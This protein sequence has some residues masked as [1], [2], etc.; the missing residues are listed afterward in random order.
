MVC[1]GD[2]RVDERRTEDRRAEDRRDGLERRGE[3]CGLHQTLKQEIDDLKDVI[4]KHIGPLLGFMNR[5]KGIGITLVII[6][7]AF[8]TF[9]L[10][11]AVLLWGAV[12][13]RQSDH[14]VKVDSKM[15]VLEQQLKQVEATANSVQ[16]SAIQIEKNQIKLQTQMKTE[17]A[18]RQELKEELRDIR[19]LL[20]QMLSADHKAQHSKQQQNKEGTNES[21]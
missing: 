8:L 10:V 11:T 7:V 2:R 6:G 12:G 4:K 5:T 9:T 16:A 20:Q 14:E 15:T 18:G 21:F 13:E 3:V 1:L 17:E 19:N